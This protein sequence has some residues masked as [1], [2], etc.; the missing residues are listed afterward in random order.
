MMRCD[1]GHYYVVKFQ[2]NPH[3]TRVLANDWLG[4]RLGRLIGLPMPDV[5]EVD[6]DPWLVEHTQESRMNYAARRCC[7]RRGCRLVRSMSSHRWKVRC[8]TTCRRR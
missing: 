4:T 5:S 6:V 1:D 7:L 3:H 8:T 2:N